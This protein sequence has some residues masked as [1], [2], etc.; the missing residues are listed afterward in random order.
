MDD[1]EV[2]THVY[3]VAMTTGKLPMASAIAANLGVSRDE[4]IEVLRRLASGRVLVLQP[5][6]EILMAAPFSAVATPFAVESGGVSYFANCVWDALGIPAMLARDGAVATSCGDCDSA[7]M[8]RI[9]SGSVHGDGLIHF[10]IPARQ[11]WNDIT[12]T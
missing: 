11:W 5:D 8:I 7:M 10:A 9:A 4:V 12:F 6:G 3:E 1:V 2:R